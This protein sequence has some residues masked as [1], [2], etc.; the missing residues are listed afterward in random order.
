MKKHYGMS[1]EEAHRGQFIKN[2]QVNHRKI[3]SMKYLLIIN[4]NQYL[5]DSIVIKFEYIADKPMA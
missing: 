1:N 5:M 4:E 3:I 2:H